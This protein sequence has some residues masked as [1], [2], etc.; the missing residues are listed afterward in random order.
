MDADFRLPSIYVD[1]YAP[2]SPGARLFRD[3]DPYEFR[4]RVY[5]CAAITFAW[6]IVQKIVLMLLTF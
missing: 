5:G 6:I 2:R 1:L 4:R 3:T